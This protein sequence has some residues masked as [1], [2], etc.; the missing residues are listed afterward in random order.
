MLTGAEILDPVGI[1]LLG[2]LRNQ[3]INLVLQVGKDL[4]VRPTEAK[5]S[6][7]E[8]ATIRHELVL[9]ESLS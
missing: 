9:A 1:S 2:R 6:Y 3:A 4:V 5:V 8:N 7:Y